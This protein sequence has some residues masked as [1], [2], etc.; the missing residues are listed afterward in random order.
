[1]TRPPWSMMLGSMV[2]LLPILMLKVWW[3][4][5]LVFLLQQ[6]NLAAED[7]MLANTQNITGSLLVV[8][9][10]V[11]HG[12]MSPLVVPWSPL[13][14]K[15]FRFMLNPVP[16]W[17]KIPKLRRKILLVAWFA[18]LVLVLNTVLEQEGTLLL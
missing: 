6:R 14:T 8:V 12:L 11:R 7:P 9:V 17:E 5:L 16:L 10:L 1:M 15:S 4:M 13:A 3:T 18:R 2:T